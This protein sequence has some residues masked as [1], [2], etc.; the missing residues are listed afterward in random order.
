MQ[1]ITTDGQE[2]QLDT[3]KMTL[4]Q[5][6]QCITFW[7]QF[8]GNLNQEFSVRSSLDRHTY[9]ELAKFKSEYQIMD[10]IPITQWIIFV[11]NQRTAELL[12]QLK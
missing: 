1:A 2:K 7:F 10:I 6:R 9:M 3:F 12:L 11:L 4:T 8:K 5:Q